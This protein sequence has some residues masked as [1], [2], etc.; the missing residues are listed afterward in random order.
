MEETTPIRAV[1]MVR[2]IRDQLAREWADK[3][4]AELVQ[5]LN[6]AGVQARDEARRGDQDSTSNKRLQPTARR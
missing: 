5:I 3:S 4:P 2:E 1:E 6:E